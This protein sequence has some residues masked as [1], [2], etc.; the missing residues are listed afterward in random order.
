[1]LGKLGVDKSVFK[2]QCDEIKSCLPASNDQCACV[3]ACVATG[4]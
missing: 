1:M 3:R 4:K 2:G